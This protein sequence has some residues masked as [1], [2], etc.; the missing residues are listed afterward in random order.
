MKAHS[1]VRHS[2]DVLRSCP[3]RPS[4]RPGAYTFLRLRSHAI[5]TFEEP[6]TVTP[7]IPTVIP[8]S[9][10]V[11]RAGMFI[12]RA[13]DHRAARCWAARTVRAALGVTRAWSGELAPTSTTRVG[14][15]PFVVTHGVANP[16]PY[17]VR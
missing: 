11:S 15:G 17:A 4:T 8:I 2:S 12:A 14:E 6:R 7:G 1:P 5:P 16:S 13:V 9:L 3:S 10:P